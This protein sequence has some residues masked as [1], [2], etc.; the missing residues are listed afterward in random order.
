MHFPKKLQNMIQPASAAEIG[1][2]W[3]RSARKG[4][5]VAKIAK[6][7]KNLGFKEQHEISNLNVQPMLGARPYRKVHLRVFSLYLCNF[8]IPSL[9]TVETYR[10]KLVGW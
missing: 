10:K 7:Q 2:R 3:S 1:T 8:P 9:R 5:K 4:R 6:N